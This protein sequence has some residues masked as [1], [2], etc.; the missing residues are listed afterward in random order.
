[1]SKYV[2]QLRR[3]TRYVD[4]NGK[5]L[6][7]EDGTAIKDEWADYTARPD[8]INPLDAELVVEFVQV[9]YPETQTFGKVTPRFKIGYNNAE[10]ADL[11]YISPDSFI[12][13]SQATVT[14]TPEGWMRVD[15]DGKIIDSNGNALGVDGS[16]VEED[17]YEI[18]KDGNII[19]ADDKLIKNRYVQFVDV[20]DA[21]ITPNSKVD[22]QPSPEDLIVFS[23]KDV[24]FTTINAGG[25]VRVCIVGE[26]PTKTYIFNATVT[27]VV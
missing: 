26:K 23:E 7:N 9:Y 11:D 6:Y 3:G 13:P 14:V 4:E 2:F 25:Y 22:I 1:M 12:L 15:S 5:T 21:T 20:V 17:Y 24:T 16:I 18:D 8:H 10:F 27:E 19:D